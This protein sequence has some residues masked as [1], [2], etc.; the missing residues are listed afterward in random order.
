MSVYLDTSA[1]LAL[2][3][4]DEERHQEAASQWARLVDADH[5]LVTGNYVLVE[6]FA[7]VQ[8][9]LGMDAVRALERDLLP[10]VEIVWV[11]EEV[12]RVAAAMLIAANRRALSLVDCTSFEIMRRP[13]L[14]QAFA[15]DRHFEEQGFA[16][17]T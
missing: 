15:F 7:I 14:V 2:L 1:L 5:A 8:R 9:R 3:D 17:V 11:D 12:H 13:G 6:T 10:L 4:A 16:T